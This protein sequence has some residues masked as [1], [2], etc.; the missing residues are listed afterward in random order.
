METRE[1]PLDWCDDCG[2]ICDMSSHCVQCDRRPSDG[3]VSDSG[4]MVCRTCEADR[5]ETADWPVL[6]LSYGRQWW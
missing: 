1:R 4:E 6:P 3:L 2:D 5:R